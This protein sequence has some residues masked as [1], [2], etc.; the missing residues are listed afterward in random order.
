[1]YGYDVKSK[2]AAKENELSFTQSFI[3]YVNFYAKNFVF[4]YFI[5]EIYLG[6][7]FYVILLYDKMR[8]KFL[9]MFLVSFFLL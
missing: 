6:Y 2:M 4:C 8:Y 1:M 7:E 5:V 3:F 9:F